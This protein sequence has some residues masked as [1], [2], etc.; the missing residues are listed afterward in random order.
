MSLSP[1]LTA[2]YNAPIILWVED[3]VTSTYLGECWNDPDI[4]FRIAGGHEGIRAVVRSARNEGLGHVF[5]FVDRDFG[6]SNRGRWRDATASA[7]FVPDVH[8]AENYLLHADH[9][10]GCDLNNGGRSPAEVEARLQ[11]CAAQ[12]VWWMACRQVLA[13]LRAQAVQDFPSHSRVQD[14]ASAERLICDSAWY[15]NLSAFTATVTGAGEVARLLAAAHAGAAAE[16]SGGEWRQTFAGKPLLRDLHAWLYNP[17]PGATTAME[18]DRDLARSVAR[19][20][21]A[22]SAAPAE[23]NEL[24]AAL[25]HRVGLAP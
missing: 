15:R 7:V 25:R 5:G 18:R 14:Q 17:P 20:Q 19:W 12:M 21:V 23:V 4:A 16:L 22:N 24:R 10:A 6:Y 11:A 2:L 9:L 13:R 3:P 1:D 8:E